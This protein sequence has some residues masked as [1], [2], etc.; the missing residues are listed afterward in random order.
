VSAVVDKVS[1]VVV[2]NAGHHIFDFFRVG[3]E[4]HNGADFRTFLSNVR[5]FFDVP[6]SDVVDIV[7][8]VVVVRVD[9]LV[10]GGKTQNGFSR[11]RFVS[12]FFISVGLFW[13]RRRRF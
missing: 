12:N 9:V 4:T 13:A 1:A 2:V 7:V 3:T 11:R 6:F 5:T 8:G 10:F